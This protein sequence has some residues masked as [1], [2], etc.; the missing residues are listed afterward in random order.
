MP[1]SSLQRIIEELS[2]VGQTP[3][4]KVWLSRRTM[5]RGERTPCRCVRS[6]THR[7]AVDLPMGNASVLRAGS[8]SGTEQNGREDDRNEVNRGRKLR[9]SIASNATP[10]PDK[11]DSCSQ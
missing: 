6:C 1:R 4:L 10:R 11:T 8:I 5:R 7:E 9:L 3:D 2:W